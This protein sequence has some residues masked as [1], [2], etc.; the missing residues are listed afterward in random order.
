MAAYASGQLLAPH[1]QVPAATF[2]EELFGHLPRAD[3][4]RWALACIQGLLSTPGKKS[5]R[6]LAAT[7]SAS[8]TA[9]QSLHQF[10]NASPWDWEPARQELLRWIEQRAQARAWTI[11]LAVLPKRG[12][13]S[14]GVHR[15]FVR[16]SGRTLNCQVG[17]GAFLSTG[18]TGLPVD[19]RLLL[20]DQWCQDPQ[21]RL[22]ARIPDTAAHDRQVWSHI[23]DLADALASR[24][25]TALPPLVA[26]MSESTDAAALMRGLSRR[27][28]DFVIAV[29]GSLPVLPC[30][31]FPGRQPGG[32]GPAGAPLGVRRLLTFSGRRHPHT[33]T[34]SAH[35]GAPR[36]VRIL[37]GLAQLPQSG[38][39]GAG[40][41]HTYRVFTEW[42]PAGG[43]HSRTW[44]TNM[45]DRRMDEL[46]TLT[47]LPSATTATL[48]DLEAHFGLLD[49]EGRS[50]PGWHHHMT[51][52]SAAYAYRRLA[53]AALLPPYGH[54]SGLRSA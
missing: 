27:G 20:P 32:A 41:Q 8:P 9:S 33:A 16:E 23:L 28:Q 38:P 40:R 30:A 39:C 46:L 43:R 18:T 1:G 31:P 54:A 50:F 48:H 51:L 22:R 4:R 15:R 14:V 29:P 7:V 26:D 21:R 2:V 34:V 25:R 45:T 13:H 5:I 52:I 47:D 49:F 3:Q 44:V 42:R 12:E 11:G 37:S 35:D 36:L 24:T 6:R 10:I 17:I 19:W 53:G